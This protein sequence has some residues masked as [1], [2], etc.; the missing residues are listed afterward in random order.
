MQTKRDYYL[1][2]F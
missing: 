2:I 1:Q